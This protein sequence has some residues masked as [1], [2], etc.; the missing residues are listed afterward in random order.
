MLQVQ[1]TLFKHYL[2]RH[3][4][5]FVA[6]MITKIT[7]GFACFRIYRHMSTL[8]QTKANRQNARRSTGPKSSE[9]KAAAA[10]NSL[11]HGLLA[12]HSVLPDEDLQEFARMTGGMLLDLKP[13]GALECEL[14]RR[15]IALSW[16]LRRVEKIEASVITWRFHQIQEELASELLER[17][18][19]K[20]P[21]IES[22]DPERYKQVQ[23]FRNYHLEAKNSDFATVGAVFVRDN[24]EENAF[25][26]LSRYETSLDRALS[27]TLHELERRQAAR[28]GQ[29]VPLPVAVDVNVSGM[30]DP[31]SDHD[32]RAEDS[33]SYEKPA[34]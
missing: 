11:T 34:P 28:K 31:R 9:G 3:D 22:S 17:L 24:R 27:R 5:N 21:S 26:K 14:V 29:P 16:R 20:R 18:T 7:N 10:L 6:Q 4:L 13:V 15:I 8:K 12:T 30:E 23:E 2:F 32:A 1:V 33:Q 19:G 25:S